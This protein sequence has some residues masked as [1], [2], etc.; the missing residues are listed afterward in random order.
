MDAA[1]TREA[2]ERAQEARQQTGMVFTGT[3]TDLIPHPSAEERQQRLGIPNT[4]GTAELATWNYLWRDP[5]AAAA[6]G[7]LNSTPHRQVLDNELYTHWGI[8]IYTEMPAGETNELVRRWW[9]II[10]L[11]T[12]EVSEVSKAQPQE[13]FSPAKYVSFAE[14]TYHGYQFAYDGRVMA[15]KTLNLSRRSSASAKGRGKIPNRSGHWLLMSN[16]FFQDHWI[17]EQGFFSEPNK[18]RIT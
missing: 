8:G 18:P 16:G 17:L 9:F 1:L 12:A 6:A 15:T 7:F 11:A 2:D 5:I 13:T 10:W 14:G 4:V 3:A